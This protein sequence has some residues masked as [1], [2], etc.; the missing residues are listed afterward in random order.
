MSQKAAKEKLKF[1]L[2]AIPARFGGG[3]KAKMCTRRTM[4]MLDVIGDMAEALNLSPKM[5]A[6]H[7]E[8]VMDAILKEA[9]ATGRI[10][11]AGDY[12]TIEPHV[13][14][15]FNGIDDTFDPARGHAVALTI[16]PGRKL[17]APKT[18]L[19]PENE[20]HP[21]VARVSSVLS[22]DAG[23]AARCNHLV[24]GHDISIVGQNLLLFDGDTAT[25]QVMLG[26][27]TLSGDFTVLANDQMRLLLKW[28]ES[29]PPSAAGNRLEF[30][31][32]SR[33]GNPK[34]VRRTIK[35]TWQIVSG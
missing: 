19:V 31:L 32:A 27:K 33:G 7:F 14:G 28:P 34:A 12:F 35:D 10:C 20:Q 18:D 3:Y 6:L 29:I 15:R 11:K 23:P 9:T 17:K 1:K 24:F 8:A 22:M 25:W 5:L 13:R 4:D 21:Y 2:D 26:D 16:K 30:A